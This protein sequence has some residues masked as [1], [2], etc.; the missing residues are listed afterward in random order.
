MTVIRLILVT[1]NKVHIIFD[2]K[3]TP[4]NKNTRLTVGVYLI[5][6]KSQYSSVVSRESV[7][8]SFLAESLEGPTSLFCDS[9]TFVIITTIT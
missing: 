8:I 3:M 9:S 1:Q 4:L 2:V 5:H 6:Q 7:R